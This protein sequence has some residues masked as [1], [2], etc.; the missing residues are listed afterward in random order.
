MKKLCLGLMLV[1]FSAGLTAQEKKAEKP[2]SGTVVTKKH[3]DTEVQPA[4]KTVKVTPKI[5]KDAQQKLNDKGYKAGTATGRMNV[6]TRAALRKYQHDEKLKVTGRLD[7]NTLSHL[8]IGAGQTV[9][10]APG[11]IGRGGKAAGHDIKEGHPVAAAKALGKGVGR[12]G[13][14]VGEGT[15][16]AVVGTKDKVAGDHKDKDT[17]AT[18]PK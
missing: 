6:T 3:V 4:P 9:G 10:A 5:I 18:P 7:E 1:A 2:P 11:E 17:A 13:K 16:S 12:F 15:K 14:K 8:N